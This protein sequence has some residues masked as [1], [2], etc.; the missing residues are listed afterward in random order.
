MKRYLG[1]KYSGGE[2]GSCNEWAAKCP[3]PA[4]ARRRYVSV[5][6]GTTLLPG[7]V[8][9]GKPM[10]NSSSSNSAVTTVCTESNC[11]KTFLRP[12]LDEG[13]SCE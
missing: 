3:G 5:L 8:S 10:H 13:L 2:N 1:G 12:V 6:A 7:W 9:G 11:Y 4:R